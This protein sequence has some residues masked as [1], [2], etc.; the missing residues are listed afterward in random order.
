[1]DTIESSSLSSPISPTTEGLPFVTTGSRSRNCLCESHGAVQCPHCVSQS[2]KPHKERHQQAKRDHAI[3][4]KEASLELQ[5]LNDYHTLLELQA[6]SRQLR[7]RLTDLKQTCA[8]MAVRVASQAVENDSRS[9]SL[10]PSPELHQINLIQLRDIFL[11]GSLQTCISVNTNQVRTLRF[12]WAR[13]ALAMHRLDIDPE[14]ISFDDKAQKKKRARGIGKI[15]GL[16]LPHAGPEL[17][18]V[19]PPRELQSALR[20]VASATLTV[21][22]CLGIVLPHPILLTPNGLSGDIISPTLSKTTVHHYHTNKTSSLQP[23][24]SLAKSATTAPSSLL[25]YVDSGAGY[26]KIGFGLGKKALAK[27]TGHVTLTSPATVRST[28][29]SMTA[30]NNMTSSFQTTTT[31]Q[32]QQHSISKRIQHATAAILL[33]SHTSSASEFALSSP[34]EQFG[35]ALQL[36]QNNVICLCI[37]AGVSPEQLWPAEAVLL[38]LFVLDQFCQQQTGVE[39]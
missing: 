2:L 14:D 15:G 29:S 18:D 21:A 12:Q 16:P 33:D 25:H 20:L 32:P 7:Q 36:L 22:R 4:K 26:L 30:T 1:M 13:K 24:S 34:N 23:T 28:T 38:N 19:L 10:P 35:I 5:Q 27:A 3:A 17:Y 11:E 9:S 37:R 6:E 8:G 31:A 39:Y